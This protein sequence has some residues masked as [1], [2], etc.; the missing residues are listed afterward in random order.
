M[1]QCSKANNKNSV[2]TAPGSEAALDYPFN[3]LQEIE[4]C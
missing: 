1:L 3:P 4:I 2:Q